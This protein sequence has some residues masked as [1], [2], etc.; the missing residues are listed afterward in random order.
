MDLY[1]FGSEYAQSYTETC[2]CGEKIEISTQKDHDGVEY[3]T[4]IYVKCSKCSKSVNFNL[5][6]N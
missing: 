1:D 5:P 3:S 4:D 6:V 2:E